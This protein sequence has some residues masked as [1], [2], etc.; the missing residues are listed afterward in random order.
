[1]LGRLLGEFHSSFDALSSQ[2]NRGRRGQQGQENLMMIQ[3]HDSTEQFSVGQMNNHRTSLQ[4]P[5]IGLTLG[6]Q[7]IQ[8]IRAE[9]LEFGTLTAILPTLWLQSLATRASPQRQLLDYVVPDS[10]GVVGNFHWSAWH[11]IS[12]LAIALVFI[13]L[14][15]SLLRFALRPSFHQQARPQDHADPLLH[16]IRV[17]TV[18]T[19]G[20]DDVEIGFDT[21]GNVTIIQTSVVTF[22]PVIVATLH[23]AVQVND[24][25]G[26]LA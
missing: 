13:Y 16:L 23:P 15:L 17:V 2:L 7:I 3:L 22:I 19:E 25:N 8:P 10:D 11:A 18:T 4:F 24:P 20:F 6:N 26:F 9:S 5:R 14:A 1:M 21:H 12:L